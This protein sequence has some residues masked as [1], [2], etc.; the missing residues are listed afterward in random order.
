[1]SHVHSGGWSRQFGVGRGG[2]MRQFS[3]WSRWAF[4]RQQLSNGTWIPNSVNICHPTDLLP[5]PRPHVLT[6]FLFF[7]F[8]F[9]DRAERHWLQFTGSDD[10]REQVMGYWCWGSLVKNSNDVFY[11]SVDGRRTDKVFNRLFGS[12]TTDWHGLYW[13]SE[14][15]LDGWM[16]R[17]I[18][19]KKNKTLI[20]LVNCSVL[21]WNCSI[22]FWNLSCHS[23]HCGKTN[24]LSRNFIIDYCGLLYLALTWTKVISTD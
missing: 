8:F 6:R 2:R 13:E 14:K 16:A 7:F 15:W 1:M 12:L 23:N 22:L 18:D 4:S 3:P 5:I 17:V 11:Y 10:Q 20:T 24:V 19:K 9:S 21:F